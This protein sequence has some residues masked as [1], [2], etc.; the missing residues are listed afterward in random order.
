MS[1]DEETKC[2]D[3]CLKLCPPL[4]VL[5]FSHK[6]KSKRDNTESGHG[7]KH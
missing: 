5:S 1:V 2:F 6:S 7:Y 4:K 3:V